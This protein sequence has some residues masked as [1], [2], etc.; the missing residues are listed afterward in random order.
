LLRG[1]L[2]AVPVFI[3]LQLSKTILS[4]R[5]VFWYRTVWLFGFEFRDEETVQKYS[6]SGNASTFFFL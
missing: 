2:E 3:Y 5:F 6:S 4:F 1:C